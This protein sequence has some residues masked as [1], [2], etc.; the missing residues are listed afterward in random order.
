MTTAPFDPHAVPLQRAASVLVL[1]DRPDLHVLCLR[2]RTGSAFVGGMTV[3]PGGGIDDHDDDAAYEPLLHGRTRGEMVE[4]LGIPDALAYWVAVVRET[5]EEVGVLLACDATGAPALAALAAR[6]RHD[7][8]RGHRRMLDVLQEESLLLEVG[9]VADIG[10]WITPVGPPRRYDTRFFVARLPR[11]QEATADEVE[12]V[13]AEWRR[14]ADALA[15]W[16]LGELVMLPPTVAWLRVLAAYGS[17]DDV[18]AAAARAEGPGS[19]PRVVGDD[20]GSFRVVLPG[21]ADHGA[22]DARDAWGWVYD[23]LLTPVTG[24]RGEEVGGC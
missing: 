13:H 17:V 8:D 23:E 11:G 22:P 9:A 4:R 24:Y 14:P 19:S 15:D 21:D 3:F 10:R 16:H 12:A 7:V 20:R 18:L 6:H 1:D 5:L 2:R